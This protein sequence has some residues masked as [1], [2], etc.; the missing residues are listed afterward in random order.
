MSEA[1][2]MLQQLVHLGQVTPANFLAHCTATQ[3]NK[4]LGRRAVDKY[5]ATDDSVIEI[6]SK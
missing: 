5:A 2:Q 6:V 3:M 4:N 1:E